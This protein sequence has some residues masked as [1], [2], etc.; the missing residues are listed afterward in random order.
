MREAVFLRLNEKKWLAVESKIK[1]G[2]DFTTEE[3]VFCFSDLSSD[4]SYSK[5]NYPTSKTTEY[6]NQ[7]CSNLYRGL[8]KSD[9]DWKQKFIQF[10]KYDLPQ[11]FYLARKQILLSFVIFTV[12][13]AI[14]IVSTH[15]DE[16]FPKIVLSDHYVEMTKENISKGDPTAVYGTE[17]EGGMFLRISIH[18]AKIA[19]LTFIVGL[20]FGIGSYVILFHNGV[21]VGAF[22]YF[23]H[24]Q[25]VFLT[26]FL[27][28]WIHGTIEISSIVIAGAAGIVVGNSFLFPGA[29]TRIESWIAGAKRGS[30]IVLGLMPL[31]LIA[32][33]LESFVTRHSE[34][35]AVVKGAIILLSLAFVLY[36]FVINPKRLYGTK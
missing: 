8:Y 14:G 26:S 3:L 5:T 12:S 35:P 23:F 22:Q 36:F 11:Q 30:K 15:F 24:T 4:L 27:S 19:L 9:D 13:M 6:L 1:K 33:F 29:Q 31:F 10:W 34:W 18:N 16:E 20:F 32:G 25:G 7:L 17:N 28:I 21:M 2:W